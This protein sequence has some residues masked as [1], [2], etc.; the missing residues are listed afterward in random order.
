MCWM[1]SIGYHVICLSINKP[2]LKMSKMDIDL[3]YFAKLEDFGLIPSEIIAAA[4]E[5]AC[6]IWFQKI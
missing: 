1:R 2:K 3:S 5:A 4:D 6:P